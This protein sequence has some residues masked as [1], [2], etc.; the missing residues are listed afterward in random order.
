MEWHDG[1]FNGNR[2][3]KSCQKCDKRFPG[4]HD[5][6]ELYA[7]DKAAYKEIKASMRQEKEV[8]AV[9]RAASTRINHHYGDKRKEKFQ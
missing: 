8:D 2:H 9:I 4:C 3:F 6:C 1:I 5:H 7:A